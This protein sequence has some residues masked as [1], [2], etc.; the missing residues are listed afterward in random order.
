[1]LFLTSRGVYCS[2]VLYFGPYCGKSVAIILTSLYIGIEHIFC[3]FEC[4]VYLSLYIYFIIYCSHLVNE[5][6]KLQESF[7]EETNQNRRLSRYT[8][9][10]K[11]KLEQNKEVVAKVIELQ[12]S[13]S[14]F[15]RSKSNSYS[16]KHSLT[17]YTLDRSMSDRAYNRSSISPEDSTRCRKD[18]FK[19]N[20]ELDD[21][22]PPTSPKVKGVV[23]KS[24]SVSYVLDL[25]ESPEV[26]ASRIVRRS[27]RNTT[28]P[29]NTPTKSPSNKRPRRVLLSQS[30]SSSAII[31]PTK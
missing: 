15:N 6:L 24:D 16:E 25:N 20:F 27:F 2:P 9:E 23:E 3:P 4:Y 26:V 17:K 11:W 7:K 14:S 19:D 21:L 10:L 30:A 18:I 12:P 5:N 29:K 13:Q 28:P 31:S 1:M 8:E 22:S